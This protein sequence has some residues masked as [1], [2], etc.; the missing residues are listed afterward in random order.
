M[1]VKSKSAGGG[2]MAANSIK[3]KAASGAAAAAKTMN[4]WLGV[5]GIAMRQLASNREIWKIIN[6]INETQ[7]MYRRKRRWRSS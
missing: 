6:E 5:S 4:Q 2:V 3:K 1:S 7:L